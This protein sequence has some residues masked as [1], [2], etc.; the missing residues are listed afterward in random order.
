MLKLEALGLLSLMLA[1][2]AF[3]HR[4]PLGVRSRLAE[5][6]SESEINSYFVHDDPVTPCLYR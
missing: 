4:P 6:A 1:R 3:N 2:A 5:L